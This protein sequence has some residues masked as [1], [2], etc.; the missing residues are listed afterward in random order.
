MPYQTTLEA[1]GLV[2]TFSGQLSGAELR[3]AVF[4]QYKDYRSDDVRYVID[5][6]LKVAVLDVSEQALD[7]ILALLLSA[8]FE[9]AD[10]RVALVATDGRIKTFADHV[11]SP[12]LPSYPT[13]VFTSLAEARVW[14]GPL[15]A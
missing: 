1:H 14:I 12:D 4:H 2:T 15:A 3:H 11:A 10:V 5:D 7:D 8:H 13:R 9:N 6:F